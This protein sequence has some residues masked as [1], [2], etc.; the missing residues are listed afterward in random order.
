MS[1]ATEAG[2]LRVGGPGCRRPGQRAPVSPGPSGLRPPEAA[3][4]P[5]LLW[6]LP[7]GSVVRGGAPAQRMSRGSSSALLT[8]R[9]RPRQRGG[10]PPGGKR[11]AVS[12]AP[13]ALASLRIPPSLGFP[14][15]FRPPTPFRTTTAPGLV[16]GWVA[17]PGQCVS[18]RSTEAGLSSPWP[19]SQHSHHILL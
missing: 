16:R 17:L 3:D 6:S 19:C 12:G 1:W 2:S 7:P 13:A 15:P 9:P 4:Q 18:P 8:P 14:L 5:V 10:A 11:W